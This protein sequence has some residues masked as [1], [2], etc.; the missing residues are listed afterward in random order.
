MLQ[1][2]WYLREKWPWGYSHIEKDPMC[3]WGKWALCEPRVFG[4]HG[5]W[6]LAHPAAEQQ[7]TALF[8][9]PVPLCMADLITK[10]GKLAD[11]GTTLKAVSRSQEILTLPKGLENLLKG[12]EERH[13][14]FKLTAYI[15]GW[16]SPGGV[17]WSKYTRF[18]NLAA[19]RASF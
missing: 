8:K 18:I 14:L 5:P 10:A 16:N 13:A 17:A 2:G 4:R 1:H 11:Q 19:R 7:G 3:W 9:P 6:S 12:G 15:L